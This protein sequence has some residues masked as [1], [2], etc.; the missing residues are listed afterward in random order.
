MKD[1]LEETMEELFYNL[2]KGGVTC[3]SVRRNLEDRNKSTF[4]KRIAF[5]AREIA[6][7]TEP[8]ICL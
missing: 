7:W 1:D 3:L 2:R 4:Y 5:R 8:M 6:G